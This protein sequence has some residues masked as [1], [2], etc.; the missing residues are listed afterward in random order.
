MP[1]HGQRTALHAHARSQRFNGRGG[2]GA[3]AGDSETN[4]FAKAAFLVH[5]EQSHARA[6]PYEQLG[7]ISSDNGS[8]STIS[9]IRCPCRVFSTPVPTRICICIWVIISGRLPS[10]HLSC[11]SFASHSTQEVHGAHLQTPPL[12]FALNPCRASLYAYRGHT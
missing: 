3:R 2:G 12:F 6:M 9:R 7:V 5:R 1:C 4:R 8:V 10:L 11:P